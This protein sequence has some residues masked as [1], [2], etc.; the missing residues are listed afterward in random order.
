MAVAVLETTP[1]QRLWRQNVSTDYIPASIGSMR[2]DEHLVHEPIVRALF[3]RT[4]SPQTM[5]V[6]LMDLR[7]RG[8]RTIPSSWPTSDIVYR[9]ANAVPQFTKQRGRVKDVNCAIAAAKHLYQRHFT[10]SEE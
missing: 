1:L 6:I 3:A 7:P 4:L 9:A 2:L 8:S 10:R 5:S